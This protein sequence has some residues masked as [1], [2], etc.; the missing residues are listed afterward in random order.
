[1]FFFLIHSSANDE[2]TEKQTLEIYDESTVIKK[3][4]NF[5]FDS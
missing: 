5:A 3:S 2:W 1:M 4:G